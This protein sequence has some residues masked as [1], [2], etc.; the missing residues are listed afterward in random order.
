MSVFKT[1]TRVAL[2]ACAL[3]AIAGSAA[4]DPTPNKQSSCFFLNEWDGWHAPNDHTL[5]LRVRIN[6]VYQLDLSSSS[7]MLTWPD[8]HLINRVHG[9]NSVCDPIDLQLSISEGHGTEEP[10]FI[11]S[12]TKLSPQ[13]IAAIPPR[14]RP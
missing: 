1:L 9:D 12:I 11:K 13:Q 6:Q 7:N 5:Y 14:D 3:A 8:S 4:A 10:L 2:G